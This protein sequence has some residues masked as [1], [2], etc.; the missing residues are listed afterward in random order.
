MIDRS[1]PPK[2][3]D[4]INFNL[5]PLQK[6]GL[7]NGLEI[8][9]SEKNSLPI[10]VLNFVLKRGSVHDPKGKSGLANLTG[11]VIDEGANG[12]DALQIDEMFEALGTIF[13]VTV[14]RD[15][16]FFSLVSLKK[17]FE[18]SLEI[19]SWILQKP[20][21][22]KEDFLR[23][24]EKL[25]SE[26]IRLKDEPSFV[27]DWALDYYLAKNTPYAYPNIGVSEEIKNITLTDVKDFYNSN[28]SPRNMFLTAVG[29][30][31]KSEFEELLN[32]Y[33]GEWNTDGSDEQE[34][35]V[36]EESSRKIILVN[37]PDAAQSEIRIGNLATPR[38]SPDYFAKKIVNTILGGQFS[39]RLN[40]N[41][42]EEKGIT[43]GVRTSFSHNLNFGFF[44]SSAAVDTANT[45]LA[46]VEFFKEFD[47]IREEIKNEEI[48]FAKSY[49]KKT[50]PS[51]FETYSKIV[52]NIS[53]QIIFDLPDDFF[54]TYLDNI[55]SVGEDE[56]KNAARNNIKPHN[57]IVVVVGNAEKLKDE[58]AELAENN[59]F[60][61]LQIEDLP[62]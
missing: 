10:V 9:F 61:V 38:H 47:L 54:E 42:R 52:A 16:I 56:I 58:L 51:Q 43:Y 55:S 2:I 20:N 5:P 46:L 25:L 26:I 44:E 62:I 53:T 17:N 45:K 4:D 59:R 22:H 60:E 24:K 41:L 48:E 19:L 14:E 21:F 6:F 32:K 7:A 12:Y 18:K 1:A 49:L 33:F 39:S 36:P 8:Y 13:G 31:N 40:H 23:E 57:Q 15:S 3:S 34:P 29:N 35:L 30:L 37:K 50:Y 28:F 11:M 27:A